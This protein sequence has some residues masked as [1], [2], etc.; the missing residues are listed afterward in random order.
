[1]KI[2]QFTLLV[3][4]FTKSPV[5]SK[6]HLKHPSLSS[7]SANPTNSD[8]HTLYKARRKSS[9]SPRP[10]IILILTD[11]QDKDLGSLQFMPKLARHLGEEGATYQHGYVS[12]PMCCP[13]RSSLLTGLYV[14][15]HHVYTNNDNCSSPYW[16]ENHEKR[17]FAT[18]L[19]QSGYHTAYYGKYLNKYTGHHV[20]PGWDEW[21]GLVRNSRFYNYTINSNGVMKQHGDD[22]ARDYLPDIITNKTLQLISRSAMSSSPFMA[23]LSYPGPHGPEDAAPQYQDMF[24]NVTTHHTPAYDFAPNPDKQWILRHTEKMLPIH[25]SFTDLLMTK[26]LQT[27]QSVDSAVEKI[28]QRL[29]DAGQLENTYIFYTS[30]HGYHLGQFGLVKGKAFPFEFDTHV[31]FL[32]RGPGI[33]PRSVRDQPVLNIDLAPTF[34]DIAGLEKP[35]HMDGKSILPT[36]RRPDKK[37]RD[38]FLIERGKMTFQRYNVVSQERRG[39]W[40]VEDASFLSK[41]PVSLTERLSVEC[42]KP[43]YQTPCSFKQ[44]WVCKKRGD[45][46]L[47]IN[48]CKDKQGLKASRT[49]YSYCR[50]N[51]G[52]KFGWKYV[53]LD[54][55][56]MKIPLSLTRKARSVMKQQGGI[57][58]LDD[59]AHEEMKEMDYLVEDIDEE[60]RDLHIFNNITKST[61]CGLSR[62]NEVCQQKVTDEEPS[63]WITSRSTIKHQ[64][65]QL[66]AQL[67]ELKQIRKYLRL[68]R[69]VQ[70]KEQEKRRHI[71]SGGSLIPF[72]EPGTEVCL[73][74]EMQGKEA[75]KQRLE[76]KDGRRREKKMERLL[77]KERKKLKAVKKN[78]SKKQDHC[79]TDVKMNCFSHD[80]NHWHTAPLWT[81]GPFC[82]CTNSNNNTY[83]CVRN[84]N[85]TH[86]YLYCEYVTGMITYFDLN[87]DPF[88][89]RNL[90]YTVPDSQLNFMHQ[91]V[92]HLR[93]FSGEKRFLERKQRKLR[94]KKNKLRQK[95]LR[96]QGMRST[97]LRR[98]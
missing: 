81:E 51:S 65:Q 98:G 89:L 6:R 84:I 2:L 53:G 57:T 29:T 39:V 44:K 85:T 30:D 1:M 71:K 62:I 82:A 50:C 35:P 68:K 67:N 73:C 14:H 52:E 11:D 28:V 80:N 48:R 4:I 33:P 17:T 19:Q 87:V 59:I 64:I 76:E 38:A 78:Q 55:H 36:F 37:L 27:L 25:R 42:K 43:R 8:V 41:N 69:P 92:T 12:T 94:L 7:T 46:S 40:D 15:N 58:M 18:Y 79:K 3:L 77:R 96:K 86:N 26:R 20:P 88:Q 31:P 72:M 63:T 23:V 90:L 83:W 70:E 91:Q 54:Q 47:K 60:I 66:R 10:N 16:V 49:K 75:I 61:G 45:G 95:S 56:G 21:H 9:S 13:S 22:Y 93:T 34:L 5:S 74:N 24:Y 97:K 32:V